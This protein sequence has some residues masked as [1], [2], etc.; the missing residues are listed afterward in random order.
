MAPVGTVCQAGALALVGVRTT[1]AGKS[2]VML[3]ALSVLPA[4][5]ALPLHTPLC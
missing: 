5:I 4:N 3:C 2:S 1:V